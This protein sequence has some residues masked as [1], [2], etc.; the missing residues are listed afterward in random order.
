MIKI[1]TSSQVYRLPGFS[2]N[3]TTSDNLKAK[4]HFT[5]V[6]DLFI[7][8]VGYWLAQEISM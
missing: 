5:I 1:F 4:N 8:L 3:Y 7:Y 6:L 2:Y